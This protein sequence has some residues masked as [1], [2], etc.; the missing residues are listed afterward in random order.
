MSATSESGFPCEHCGAD[1]RY[2]IAKKALESRREPLLDL[3][4][5]TV[6]DASVDEA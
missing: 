5:D 4:V 1:G 3:C 2:G 6:I